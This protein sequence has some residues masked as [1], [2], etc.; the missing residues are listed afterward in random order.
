MPAHKGYRPPAA[1]MGRKL[2]SKNKLTKKAKEAFQLAFEGAGGVEALTAWAIEN[3]TEFYKLY[4]RLI[5]VDVTSS[6]GS[7]RR[8]SELTDDE[9]AAIA[10]GCSPDA[11][12]AAGDSQL[13]H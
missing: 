11:L 12:A 5:P 10:A 9:L 7:L 8:A 4:S 3:R 2:G 1:G 6:D 13:T